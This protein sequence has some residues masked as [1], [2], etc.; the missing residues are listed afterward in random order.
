M[1]EINEKTKALSWNEVSGLL[2][3]NS[4]RAHLIRQASL[5]GRLVS[6]K[7]TIDEADLSMVEFWIQIHGL[8]LE[9]VD[10]VNARLIG[11][12]LGEVL[13]MD[14]IEAHQSFIGLKVRFSASTPLEPGFYFTSDEGAALWIGFKYE[15]LSCFCVH[16]GLIDHTIGTCYQNPAHPQN[17]ALTDKIR[18]FLPLQHNAKLVSD[19]SRGSKQEGSWRRPL[20]QTEATRTVD[21][22]TTI[23]PPLSRVEATVVKPFSGQ[24]MNSKIAWAGIHYSTLANSICPASSV[25]FNQTS[26]WQKTDLR[27]A[28]NGIR[29]NLEHGPTN[30]NVQNQ[31]DCLAKNPRESFATQKSLDVTREHFGELQIRKDGPDDDLARTW[32]KSGGPWGSPLSAHLPP[33]SNYKQSSPICI[34]SH[35]SGNDSLAHYGSRRSDGAKRNW[36]KQEAR[37]GSSLKKGKEELPS[38]A[39]QQ[40]L[41]LSELFHP[42]VS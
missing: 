32:A 8:P 21:I 16:C 20:N 38:V 29:I 40:E 22:G 23:T 25:G 9:I 26:L 1:D 37:E 12:K 6:K 24:A 4:T 19:H 35:T 11:C 34:N 18:G 14:A 42:G 15:R 3:P 13:E 31:D 41:L 39:Y 30:L 36:E 2:K 17:Y 5:V 10:E 33:A 28:N 27:A 7:E